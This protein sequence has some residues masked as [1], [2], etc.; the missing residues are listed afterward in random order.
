MPLHRIGTPNRDT[1]SAFLKTKVIADV[2]PTK[3]SVVVDLVCNGQTATVPT[4]AVHRNVG[5]CVYAIG[6]ITSERLLIDPL[7]ESVVNFCRLIVP[8]GCLKE[9]S[10]RSLEELK[11]CWAN[12]DHAECTHIVLIGHA[13]ENGI[14]FAVDGQVKPE[15]LGCAFATENSIAT[16]IVSLCCKTGR[17]DFAKPFANA[18]NIDCFIAPF[19][20]V[21]G[22][23]ASQ[24]FQ[25]YLG[26][27]FLNGKT[28]KVAF[29]N[30][31]SD[32][33]TGINFRR[34]KNGE[35][36]KS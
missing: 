1:G 28:T 11:T 36:D 6:D 13:D 21:H 14:K 31:Q 15:D 17:A 34:W 30:A 24:F 22:A 8:A 2:V 35:L 9:R 26:Q 3:R 32:I 23:I 33:P 16:T 20:S 18:S 27:H 12:Y 29:K 10:V 4:S 19:Q 7:K 25:T 5:V